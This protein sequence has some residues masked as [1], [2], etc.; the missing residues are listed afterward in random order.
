MSMWRSLNVDDLFH[1]ELID[2]ILHHT[3]QEEHLPA[4]LAQI[5]VFCV[6]QGLH[7]QSL[8]LAVRLWDQEAND[9]SGGGQLAD[10]LWVFGAGKDWHVWPVLSNIP[11]Q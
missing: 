11:R 9:A 8:V 10:D 6:P 2:A 7:D 4:G 5:G 3:V 1:S